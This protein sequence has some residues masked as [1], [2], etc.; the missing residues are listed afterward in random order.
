[1]ARAFDDASTE[2]LRSSTFSRVSLPVTLAAWVYS[3]DITK[4]Q[5][6][7]SLIDAAD[8]TY[9]Y[10]GL[11]MRGNE[12]GDPVSA[13]Q[14]YVAAAGIS[15]SGSGFSANT[16]HH[17]TGVFASNDSRTVYFDGAAGT[18]NT[19]SI[20]GNGYTRIEIGR[21]AQGDEGSPTQYMSGNVAE[22]AA[23]D[24][25]LTAAEIS[26][27][28]DGYSPE[29]IRPTSLIAYW[30]LFGNLSPEIARVGGS[31]YDLTL[32][33]TPTKAAHPGMIYPIPQIHTVP[34]AA[35]EGRTTYNTDSH[36]LGIHTGMAWRINQP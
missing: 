19:T 7:I 16:W 2:Y 9:D 35:V 6:P 27:L 25:A 32:F 22:A 1:M 11:Q 4:H 29:L 36:P 18:E 5:R 24:V 13:L 12:T 31:G 26:S 28:A 33:N 21:V 17:L 30:Q 3:D 34:T 23:W 20:T 14:Q 8:G 10:I 15:K